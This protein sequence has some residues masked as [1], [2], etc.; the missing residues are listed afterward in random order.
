MQ[1]EFLYLKDSR[2]KQ[3]VKVILIK[4]GHNIGR[5]DRTHQLGKDNRLSVLEIAREIF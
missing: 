1:T 4:K 3:D 5:R 2:R